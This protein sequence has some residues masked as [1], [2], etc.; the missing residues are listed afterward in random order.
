MEK[1]AGKINLHKSMNAELK[2]NESFSPSERNSD[3]SL[4][5][6]RIMSANLSRTS[7]P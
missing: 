5:R 6:P 3:T 1:I 4:K 7:L 2:F